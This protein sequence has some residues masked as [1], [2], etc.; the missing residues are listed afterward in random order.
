MSRTRH[1]RRTVLQGIGAAVAAAAVP[2]TATAAAA[3]EWKIVETPVDGTLHDVAGTTAGAY[4]VGS[5]GVV[6]E[7]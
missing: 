6:I 5:G 3:A 4:A 7:R 1:T 2:A